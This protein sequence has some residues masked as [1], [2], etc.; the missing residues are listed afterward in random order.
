M[1]GGV[2][3]HYTLVLVGTAALLGFGMMSLT[4]VGGL[5]VVL[6]VLVAWGVLALV[7]GQD[8]VAVPLFALRLFHR[9]PTRIVSYSRSPQRVVIEE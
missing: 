2:P 8:R 3:A 5:L 6:G 4:R 9:F 7:Y 1:L